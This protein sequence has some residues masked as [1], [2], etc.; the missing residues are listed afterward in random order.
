MNTLTLS[1]LPEKLG[2]CRLPSGEPIPSWL[3]MHH[4]ISITKTDDELSIV[5]TLESIPNNVKVEKTWRA[6]K[7][8]GPL[9]FSITGLLASILNPLVA[10][11]ISIFA[12]STFDTDYILI[13][14]ENLEKA[15]VVLQ[16]HNFIIKKAD[17]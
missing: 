3:N 5:C 1:V 9:D 15:I 12:I 14:E 4:F 6:L 17:Q 13:K 16:A 10:A 11:T 2:I 8:Q 7:V